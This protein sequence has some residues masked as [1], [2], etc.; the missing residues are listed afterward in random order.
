MIYMFSLM[1]IYRK[2]KNYLDVMTN[3]TMR[4]RP[5]GNLVCSSQKSWSFKTESTSSHEIS[6]DILFTSYFHKR[7]DLE[8][9]CKNIS[10]YIACR[11]PNIRWCSGICKHNDDKFMVPYLSTGPVFNPQRA[12]T[13]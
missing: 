13:E 10:N 3:C 8:Q 2:Y 5:Q 12:G 9:Y 6:L 11:C 1:V 7:L 4:S